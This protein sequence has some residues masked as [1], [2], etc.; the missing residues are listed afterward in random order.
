MADVAHELRGEGLVDEV[1]RVTHRGGKSAAVNLGLEVC[2]GDIIVIADIDTSLDRDALA[3]MLG[4]FANDPRLGAVGGDLGVRNECASLVTRCQAIEYGI[5]VSL[6]R[7]VADM[8]GILS[9]VSGAFGAFRRSAIEGVGGQDVEVG[10]DADLTMKLRRAGWR[11]GFAPEARALT[12][13]PETVSSLIAQRLRWDRGIVTIWLRKYR[14]VFDPRQSTFRALDVLASLDVLVFQFLLPL[15][16]PVYL[17]WLWWHFGAF[18]IILLGATVLGY[19]IVDVVAV[20]AAAAVR[21]ERPLGVVIYL[22]IYTI[23]RL[24]LRIVRLIAIF[25]ELIFRTSYRD[26]YVPARV[27]RRAARV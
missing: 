6:G 18:A 16:F 22:P 15:V 19:L 13:V 24:V 25:Q 26:P 20:I 7:R 12:Q 1:I 21:V 2:T 27:M 17:V 10:E 11:I 4:Y 14:A 3:V 23:L 8:L 5:S 9:M